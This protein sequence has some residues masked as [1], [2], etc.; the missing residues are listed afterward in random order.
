MTNTDTPQ[1]PSPK[2]R[3]YLDDG[4]RNPLINAKPLHMYLHALFCHWV[5][6]HRHTHD[7]VHAAEHAATDLYFDHK[8]GAPAV[9][10]LDADGPRFVLPGPPQ[11]PS[12]EDLMQAPRR[13]LGEDGSTSVD[14]DIEPYCDVLRPVFAQWLAAGFH[15]RDFI[16]ATRDEAVSV[17]QD[18]D[19]CRD[20]CGLGGCQSAAEY[21][22]GPPEL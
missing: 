3:F 20:L 13:Y 21:L 14:I 2:I 15:A 4:E 16:Q 6:S 18:Y 9:V 7:F 10:T 5:K 22:E 17:V 19:A 1:S 11:A 12:Q 8:L